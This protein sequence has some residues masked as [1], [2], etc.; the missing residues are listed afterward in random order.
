MLRDRGRIKWTAM[1][2]PEHVRLLREWKEEGGHRKPIE[3][4]EQQHEEWHYVISQ[5]M[6]DHMQLLIRYSERT[7]SKEEAF[8]YIHISSSTEGCFA[9]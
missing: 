1:M 9:S 7:R 4:D 6:T 8:G 3:I 2:L 5:S